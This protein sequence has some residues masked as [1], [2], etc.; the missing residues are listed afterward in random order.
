M[1]MGKATVSYYTSWVVAYSDTGILDYYR[2]WYTSRY[3]TII[4][5]PK[6]GSHISIVRGEEDGIFEGD[7]HR[8]I[9]SGIEIEFN[10]S[11]EIQSNNTHVWLPVWGD[12]VVKL[13]T[14]LGL[15]E[16]P[17]FDYHLTLGMFPC[18]QEMKGKIYGGPRKKGKE[19]GCEC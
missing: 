13:R 4:H 9:D 8:N 2:W 11:N 18:Y 19:D 12:E 15:S 17:K 6:H 1:Y 7:W 14:D 5:P 3:G 10:Y 16:K